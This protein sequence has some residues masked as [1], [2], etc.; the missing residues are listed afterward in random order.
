MTRSTMAQARRRIR[1][2]SFTRRRP[3]APFSRIRGMTP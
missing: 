1:G 2:T 3:S